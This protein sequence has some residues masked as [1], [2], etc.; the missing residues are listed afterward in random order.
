MIQNKL[1]MKKNIALIGFMGSGKTAVGKKLAQRLKLKFVDLDSLIEQREKKPITQIFSQNGEPYF[2]KIEKEMVKEV[3]GLEGL[4][5]A[6]GGGVV[7]D[8][9]NLD[10]LKKSGSVIYLK[11]TLEVIFKRTKGYKHRPLLNVEEP[12]KKIGE[13]LKFREPLYLKAGHTIDTSCLDVEGVVEEILK[14]IK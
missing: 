6:C 3:S 10:N 5:I 2:R 4:V 11:A 7:L 8:N 1:K 14:I 13:L 12:E 9:E